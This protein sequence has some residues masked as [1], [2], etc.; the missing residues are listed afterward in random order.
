MADKAREAFVSAASSGVL[1]S[2]TTGSYDI[3]GVAGGICSVG[4]AAALVQGHQQLRDPEGTILCFPLLF[5]PS[6]HLYNQ[7]PAL[8]VS[9]LEILKV[10]SERA[11]KRAPN[12][13]KF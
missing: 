2:L 7:F 3:P 9:V 1:G 10:A 13:Q 12:R 8:I 4:G 6:Q 11:L 5:Q